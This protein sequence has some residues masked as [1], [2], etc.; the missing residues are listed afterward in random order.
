MAGMVMRGCIM[1]GEF[2]Y[3]NTQIIF[4]SILSFINIDFT[5]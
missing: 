3:Y 2:Q 5:N 4:N 1:A